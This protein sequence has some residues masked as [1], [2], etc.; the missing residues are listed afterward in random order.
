MPCVRLL[1]HVRLKDALREATRPVAQAWRNG[2][3]ASAGYVANMTKALS[4]PVA[5]KGAFG[6]YGKCVLAPH[7]AAEKLVVCQRKAYPGA[8][9]ES[10]RN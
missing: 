10:R 6:P 1:R 8:L 3:R 5:R 7:Q 2:G 4:G 9:L